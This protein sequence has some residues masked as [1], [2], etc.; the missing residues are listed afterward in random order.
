MSKSLGNGVDPKE[1]I[2]AYGSDALR[3]YLLKEV[4]T[5]DDGDFTMERLAAVYASDLANDYGNVVSRVVAM[6]K[7][8]CNGVPSIEAERVQNLE[9]ALVEEAWPQ[10]HALI[11]VRKIDEA[12]AV[13]H[14]LIVFCNRRIEEQKPWAMAKDESRKKDLEE[15]LYE[16]LEIIR[17]VTAMI[18]PAIPQAAKRVQEEVFAGLSPE[19]A[20]ASDWGGVQPGSALPE[21]GTILFPRTVT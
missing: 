8:Y 2:T 5:L 1:A 12:L 3:W 16:L 20:C 7:K 10:F 19:E 21:G 18:A 14:G 15:L 4:P 11:E 17:Q 9:K 13:A 6:A